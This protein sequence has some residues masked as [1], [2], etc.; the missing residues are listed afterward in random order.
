MDRRNNCYVDTSAFI[1][2]LA[3]SDKYHSLFRRLFAEA[4]PLVTSALT[5]AEGHA[6]FLRKYDVERAARFLS[7][8]RQLPR[9][10][11]EPFD[12]GV[13]VD[14]AAVAARF[15]DQ[16][17]TLADAHAL[18]IMKRYGLKCCWSTD[19]HLELTGVPLAIREN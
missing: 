18:A 4:P 11:I 2:F 13:L 9:L 15:K 3:S 14:V 6:W 10:T 8:V 7:F 5:I 12:K 16:E 1:S 17:L 19:R